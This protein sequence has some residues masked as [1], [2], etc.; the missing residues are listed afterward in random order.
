MQQMLLIEINAVYFWG[1]GNQDIGVN[2]FHIYDLKMAL[3]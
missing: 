3:Q 2:G 1:M